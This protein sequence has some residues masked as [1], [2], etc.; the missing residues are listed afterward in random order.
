MAEPVYD[1]CFCPQCRFPLDGLPETAEACPKCNHPLY[2]NEVWATRKY[3]G[4]VELPGWVRA[5]GW[6]FLLMLAGVGIAVAYYF[7]GYRMPV[8]LPALLVA[9]GLVWFVVKLF[10]MDE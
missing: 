9:F 1:H 6:P 7:A 4:V 5:F 8:H 3:P 10:G 2:R